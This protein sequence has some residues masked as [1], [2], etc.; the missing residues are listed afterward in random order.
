M[1]I[2]TKKTDKLIMVYFWCITLALLERVSLNMLE[3]W[4][5]PRGTCGRGVVTL[6]GCAR[7]V[8]DAS[9]AAQGWWP[10]SHWA[11]LVC[12]LPT[13]S[14]WIHLGLVSQALGMVA[15]IMCLKEMAAAQNVRSQS[16]PRTH[17]WSIPMI[18]TLLTRLNHLRSFVELLRSIRL[19]HS[20]S[21]HTRF[22]SHSRNKLQPGV[23][24]VWF[25]DILSALFRYMSW[26]KLEPDMHRAT[27]THSPPC[28][29]WFTALFAHLSHKYKTM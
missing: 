15:Q 24:L 13:V 28:C 16:I 27:S 19:D 5:V 14:S 20:V 2:P 21:I 29:W 25:G 8:H 6:V 22:W 4:R 18:H 23:L 1:A 12:G 3:F 10:F 11:C 26:P 17:R 7:A 9:A